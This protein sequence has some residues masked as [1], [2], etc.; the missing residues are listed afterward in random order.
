MFNETKSPM[1]D[2]WGTIG[3]YLDVALCDY[4]IIAKDLGT[5]TT[6]K[7]RTRVLQNKNGVEP[8]IKIK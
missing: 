4:G 1:I 6:V 7:I 5:T 3:L 8:N 2:Q